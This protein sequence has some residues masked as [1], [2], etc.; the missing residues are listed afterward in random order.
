[1]GKVGAIWRVNVILTSISCQDQDMFVAF[2]SLWIS[3]AAGGVPPNRGAVTMKSL[4]IWIFW[5]LASMAVG[6][7]IGAWSLDED[8]AIAVGALAGGF[9]YSCLGLWQNW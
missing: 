6:G 5:L 3:P 7:T 8:Y 2:G 4:A 9:T 1:V